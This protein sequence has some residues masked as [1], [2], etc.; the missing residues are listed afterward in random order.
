MTKKEAI[1]WADHFP[2]N[3]NLWYGVYKMNNYYVVGCSGYFKR[4]PHVKIIYKTIK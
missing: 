3:Q 1:K 2:I 4:N